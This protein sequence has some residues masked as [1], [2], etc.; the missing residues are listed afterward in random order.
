MAFVNGFDSDIFIS[1]SHIDNEPHP[2]RGI[3]WVE[4]FH[5]C[6]AYELQTRLGT[7][8]I[9][10]WRDT[11][12]NGNQ[13]FD[14]TL[15][16]KL[17]KSAILLCLNSN[18]Y[19]GS[20]YCAD[21]RDWFRAANRDRLQV[22]DRSRIFNILLV[23]TPFSQWPEAFAGTSG[24]PFF[25]GSGANSLRLDVWDP[26]FTEHFHP[27]T[28]ALNTTLMSMKNTSETKP[29]SVVVS[30]K[31]PRMFFAKV[32]D[33]LDDCRTRVIENLKRDGVDVI[34]SAPPPF[35][36]P[37]HDEA[38]EKQLQQA[39]GAIHLLDAYQGAKIPGAAKG[40][41]QRQAEIG[42]DLKARQFVWMPKDLILD[43]TSVPPA[44]YRSFLRD[45][46]SGGRNNP[47]SEFV[48]G[49]G[50][51]SAI[52]DE[53][54][55]WIKRWYPPKSEQPSATDSKAAPSILL[56]FHPKDVTYFFE[57]YRYLEG[58]GIQA[59]LNQS[60]D[61]PRRNADG[62]EDQLQHVNAFIV[63]FGNVA[64]DW[65]FER[66]FTA[67]RTVALRRC[68]VKV[69]GIYLLPPGGVDG[70]LPD[71]WRP[72]TV[73]P[74]DNTGGGGGGFNPASLIPLLTGLTPP[75]ASVTHG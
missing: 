60:F 57:L 18:S 50:A 34:E 48:R 69:F 43:E 3:R 55:Q 4:K 5:E 17:G 68:P 42:R 15:Q 39:D 36:N 1:Y 53:I 19:L 38:V 66:L 51:S 30:P 29:A 52:A 7:R 11:E 28:T 73:Y 71:D 31:G 20:K 16:S 26:A 54:R 22:A 25:E 10:I 45:V 47:A 33:S 40:Y 65:V 67:A 70:G 64:K 61:D 23:D 6:L 21:E 74:I 35:D 75:R 9:A 2:T 32:S 59:K 12:L 62:F 41:I 72:L 58:Q 49:V 24:F 27:L 8:D 44:E 56:D 13:K 14:Q 37:A 46:E 63:F